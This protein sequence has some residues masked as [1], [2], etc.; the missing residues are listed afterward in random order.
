M[1]GKGEEETCSTDHLLSYPSIWGGVWDQFRNIVR[2]ALESNRPTYDQK[3][4]G[5]QNDVSTN[6]QWFDLVLVVFRTVESLARENGCIHT[7]HDTRLAEIFCRVYADVDN[8][9]PCIS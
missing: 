9:C 3:H 4:H 7:T 5:D 8:V 2:L 6:C 1:D